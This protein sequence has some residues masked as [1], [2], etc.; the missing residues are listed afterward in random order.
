MEL[1]PRPPAAQSPRF[2][3]LLARVKGLLARPASE[4]A[5]IAAEPTGSFDVVTRYAVPLAAVGAVALFVGQVAI[6]LA[7]PLIG[8]VRASAFAASFTAAVLLVLSILVVL[9][10]A[11]I[12][13]LL[14]PR[15]GG[16]RNLARAIKL[17]AYSH[18]PLWL[19]GIAYAVPWIGFLWII[20]GVYS[21]YVAALGMPVMMR[22]PKERAPAYAIAAGLCGFVLFA[23]VGSTIA[24]LTGFGP[25][26][27]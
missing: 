3:P 22:C 8:I 12:V 16:E 21:I 20:G 26:L 25:D 2:P 14:A 17:A 10:I 6:G 19:A 15:F 9:G 18:T 4:W 27:L 7:V 24:A 11:A 5:V 23:I 13:N 1:A